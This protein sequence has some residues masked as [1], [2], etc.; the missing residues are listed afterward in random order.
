MY[1]SC[2]SKRSTIYNGTSVHSILLVECYSLFICGFALIFCTFWFCTYKLMSVDVCMRAP[3]IYWTRIQPR[4]PRSFLRVRYIYSYNLKCLS[5]FQPPCD[6]RNSLGSYS[7][8]TLLKSTRVQ[9]GCTQ[10][11]LVNT[12]NTDFFKKSV[13]RLTLNN[14]LIRQMIFMVC[15][16][17]LHMYIFFYRYLW[18]KI[19]Y[20]PQDWMAL[21]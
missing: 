2:T 19:P 13:L 15:L 5:P 7:S 12:K 11:L 4:T 18:K 3:F 17:L 20:S 1:C 6:L 10:V 9:Y 16:R 8:C 14:W 21:L